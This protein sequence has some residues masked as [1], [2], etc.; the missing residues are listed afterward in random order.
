MSYYNRFPNRTLCE[1]FDEMRKCIE[2]LNFGN[3]KGLVEE[4][5]MM[6]NRMEAALDDKRDYRESK[7]QLVKDIEE[8]ER[9]D[10]KKRMIEILKKYQEEV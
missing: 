2:T 10:K 6:G 7:N 1:V 4:G 9:E 8:I 3:L 5:Q